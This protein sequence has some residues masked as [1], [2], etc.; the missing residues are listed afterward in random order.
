MPPLLLPPPVPPLL[1]PCPVVPRGLLQSPPALLHLSP[2]VEVSQPEAL[3]PPP[4]PPHR[5]SL[6]MAVFLPVQQPG[7]QLAQW[8]LVHLRLLSPLQP[9][10]QARPP[11]ALLLQRRRP[12]R[13]L[14]R[15]PQ[16]RQA[17]LP[18][19]SRPL[20]QLPRLV[21]QQADISWQVGPLARLLVQALLPVR[22][23]FRVA[24]V[25]PPLRLA[26]PL[27]S[28]SRTA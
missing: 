26:L 3:L 5:S 2:S 27:P 24:T 21:V 25:M 10:L 28:P 7:Q 1:L 22:L 6:W 16:S 8:H 18:L 9:L 13:A 15:L 20:L 14:L 4:A 23:P 12:Q 19:P 11:P 17:A